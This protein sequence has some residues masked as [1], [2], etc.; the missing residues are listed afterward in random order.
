M[1]PGRKRAEFQQVLPAADAAVFADPSCTDTRAMHQR[2]RRQL[3]KCRAQFSLPHGCRIPRVNMAG[4][5][6]TAHAVSR[7]TYLEI[8]SRKLPASGEGLAKA[9]PDSRLFQR[10]DREATLSPPPQAIEL[11]SSSACAISPGPLPYAS[12]N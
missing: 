2:E 6:R 8:R 4:L 1:D 12:P 9:S 11:G 5:T 10:P 7:F 3:I